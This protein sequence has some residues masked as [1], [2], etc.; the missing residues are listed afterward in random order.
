MEFNNQISF[1]QGLKDNKFNI[2]IGQKK[3]TVKAK[4]PF[5]LILKIFLILSSGNTILSHLKLVSDKQDCAAFG[6]L[7]GNRWKLLRYK[8]AF[9][10][11]LKIQPHFF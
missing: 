5:S 6:N 8:L 11:K 1:L 7:S 9:T 2:K 3:K 4:Q 10:V